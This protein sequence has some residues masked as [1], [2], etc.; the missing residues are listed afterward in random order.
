VAQILKVYGQEVWIRAEDDI[1]ISQRAN[2]A[3]CHKPEP[4]VVQP[5]V[6]VV[7]F[8]VLTEVPNHTRV[9]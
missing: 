2:L 4:P 1:D 9:D 3:A 8:D 5:T 6:F 7:E